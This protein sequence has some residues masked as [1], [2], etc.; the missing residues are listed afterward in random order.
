M[1]PR[2]KRRGSRRPRPSTRPAQAPSIPV[3]LARNAAASAGARRRRHLRSA[4]Q[5][6]PTPG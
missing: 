1:I 3:D 2:S 4:D 6:P 5:P